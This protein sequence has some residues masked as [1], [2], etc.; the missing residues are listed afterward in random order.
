[1]IQNVLQTLGVQAFGMKRQQNMMIFIEETGGLKQ[2]MLVA[3]P[4]SSPSVFDGPRILSPRSQP[5]NMGSF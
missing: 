4:R 1:M 3:R 2:M 5:W